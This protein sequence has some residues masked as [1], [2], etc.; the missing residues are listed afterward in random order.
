MTDEMLFLFS[1]IEIKMKRL[2]NIDNY[3]A[4]NDEEKKQ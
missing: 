2:Q 1:I 4:D 3:D